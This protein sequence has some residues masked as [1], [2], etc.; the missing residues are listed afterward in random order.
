[1]DFELLGFA[2]TGL[3]LIEELNLGSQAILVTSRYE[4]ERILKDCL[5]LGVRLIPKNLVGFVPVGIKADK[6]DSVDKVDKVLEAL[7]KP[8]ALPS[9][10]FAGRGEEGAVTSPAAVLIDDDPLVRLVWKTSARNQGVAL[11]AFSSPREFSSLAVPPSTPV[12]I[13]SELGQE[14]KGQDFARELHSQGFANL[15]LC[16]GHSPESLPPMPWIKQILGKEPP[17][18]A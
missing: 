6:V 8:L 15:Y 14:T 18:G 1:M 5:R 7:E 16:T 10:R 2:E 4:E 3:A 13:D 9:P 11:Q 12:Y 17:W